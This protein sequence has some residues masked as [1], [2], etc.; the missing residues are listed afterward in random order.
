MADGSIVIGTTMVL[1]DQSEV[2]TNLAANNR[3]K[4]GADWNQPTNSLSREL[5]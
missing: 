3:A 2:P 4:A 5:E 1:P